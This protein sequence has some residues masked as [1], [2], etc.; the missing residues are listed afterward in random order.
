M[1]IAFSWD[2][3]SFIPLMGVNIGVISLVGRYMGARDPDTAHKATHSALKMALAYTTC[4]FLV[5][6]LFPHPLVEIFRSRQ[7]P[8][9]F[10]EVRPLAVFMVRLVAL[11]VMAD[12]IGIVFGG[13]LRGAGDTFRTMLLSVSG[14]W[15]LALAGIL[16]VRV[17]HA[18][19]RVTWA[20]VVV[21][22]V[23]VGAAMY[24]RYRTGRWR[25]IRMVDA[26]PAVGPGMPQTAAGM[27]FTDEA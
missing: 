5:F 24:L 2:M 15:L 18:P 14:H 7:D 1:T 10:V 21:M 12:G 8:A 22:V 25:H 13:A 4:T 16:L 17:V 9:A 11:Y 23:A 6:S 26:P 19:P 3:V 27:P 20:V